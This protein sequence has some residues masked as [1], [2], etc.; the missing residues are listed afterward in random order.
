MKGS[1][2]SYFFLWIIVVSQM[3]AI[4]IQFKQTDNEIQYL[5]AICEG[6]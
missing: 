3:V 6:N 1:S 5:R 2:L 4:H